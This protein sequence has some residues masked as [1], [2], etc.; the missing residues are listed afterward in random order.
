MPRKHPHSRPSG[1]VRER[2]VDAYRVRETLSA[3]TL[4][5]TVVAAADFK[6]NCLALMDEVHE[7][8]AE[9]VIT[10]HN[11]PVARLVP[12]LDPA[13]TPFVGRGAGIIAV[14]GDI[15]SPTAP[16]WDE[17]ADI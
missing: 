16:D 17:G 2:A 15:V 3:A 6:A 12:V 8:G 11:K 1:T 4:R 9:F 14:T 7:T 13:G 10:K 5:G